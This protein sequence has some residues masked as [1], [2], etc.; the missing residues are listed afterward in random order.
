MTKTYI[1]RTVYIAKCG[2]CDFK[3]IKTDLPPREVFCTKCSIWVP[4]EE[5]SY[6]GPDLKK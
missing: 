3:D 4:Y 6:I 1:K 2:I 5:K